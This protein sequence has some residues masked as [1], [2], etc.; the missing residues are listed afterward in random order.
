MSKHE[1]N[2][3]KHAVATCNTSGTNMHTNSLNLAGNNATLL[4][5]TLHDDIA[6]TSA[7]LK[8]LVDLNMYKCR[9]IHQLMWHATG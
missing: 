9:G 5:H 6:H 3:V 4:Y 7:G 8:Y 1:F 2:F